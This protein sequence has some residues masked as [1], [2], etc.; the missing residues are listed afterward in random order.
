M[1]RVTLKNTGQ[2]TGQEVVQV[3]VSDVKSRVE[4][5]KKELAGFAK[6]ELKPGETRTVDIPL[7]WTGFKFFDVEQ[8]QWVLESGEFLIHIGGSSD[9]LPLQKSIQL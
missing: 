1:A 2:L 4:Q 9:V 8:N 6:V 5:A 3:Y 7:H